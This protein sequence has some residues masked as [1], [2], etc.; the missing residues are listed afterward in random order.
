MQDR[1]I[2]RGLVVRLIQ[3]FGGECPSLVH[4]YLHVDILIMNRC[5][6]ASLSLPSSPL[7]TCQRELTRLCSTILISR[8]WISSRLPL[9]LRRL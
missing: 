2:V 8:L 7:L 6:D 5:N 3:R 9:V 4:T 1:Q